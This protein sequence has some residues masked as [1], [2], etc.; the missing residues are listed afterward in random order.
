M[1][2]LVMVKLVT[3]VTFLL[4]ERLKDR[5]LDIDLFQLQCGNVLIELL[6]YLIYKT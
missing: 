5:Y 4:K 6:N 3:K 2:I 1:A